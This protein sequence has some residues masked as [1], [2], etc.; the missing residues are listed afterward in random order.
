MEGQ[1]QEFQWGRRTTTRT[2]GSGGGSPRGRTERKILT[3]IRSEGRGFGTGTTRPRHVPSRSFTNLVRGV[4]PTFYD[5][6]P[7][8]KTTRD[9]Q[10]TSSSLLS[11]SKDL[12]RNSPTV[13]LTEYDDGTKESLITLW[14][15]KEEGTDLLLIS[16]GGN[17]RVKSFPTDTRLLPSHKRRRVPWKRTRSRV[18]RTFPVCREIVWSLV[19]TYPGC[20]LGTGSRVPCLKVSHN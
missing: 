9:L 18:G 12:Q 14:G 17:K 8:P 7:R 6:R 10:M 20:T 11:N 16:V 5:S 15:W 13:G 1:V 3:R 2:G 19:G 4:G